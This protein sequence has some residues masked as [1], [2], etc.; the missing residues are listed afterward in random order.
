M[1]VCHEETFGPL[2]AVIPV[3]NSQQAIREANATPYGLTAS[4]WSRNARRAWQ[5]A[6]QLQV[7]TVAINDHLWPFLAPEVPW[8]GVKASGLGRVGGEWGL[9]AMTTPKVISR[10]MFSPRREF[11][12]HPVTIRQHA[13]LRQLVPML[14]H[15][16]WR[17]KWRGLVALMRSLVFNRLPDQD[18]S[19]REIPPSSDRH[20]LRE[21]GT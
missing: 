11:Y 14:Y 1:R 5:I 3:E 20:S 6:G 16:R 17:V 2:V 4:V 10:D 15:P 9:R 12:W 18:G 13:L 19:K 21:E 8:G 7:G